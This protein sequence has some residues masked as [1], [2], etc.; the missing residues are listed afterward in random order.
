MGAAGLFLLSQLG[1]VFNADIEAAMQRLLG[2][3]FTL[4][5]DQS[6]L[7]SIWLGAI[8]V[9][10]TLGALAPILGYTLLATNVTS[11]SRIAPAGGVAALAIQ[12]ES[13]LRVSLGLLVSSILAILL[14]PSPVGLCGALIATCYVAIKTASVFKE[15]FDLL[16]RPERYDAGARRY[17]ENQV[18]ALKFR[19]LTDKQIAKTNELNEEFGRHIERLPQGSFATQW[20]RG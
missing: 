6:N 1:W 7:Y 9:H 5:R 19:E 14:A 11:A 18:S 4:I 17:L 8:G 3:Q 12:W 15:G 13:C 2:T 10:A 20:C 16:E